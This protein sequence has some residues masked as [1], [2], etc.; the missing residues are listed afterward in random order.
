MITPRVSRRH[1]PLF[2]FTLFAVAAVLIGL[3]GFAAIT[4]PRL[5]DNGA[6]EPGLPAEESA[7]PVE[8]AMPPSEPPLSPPEAAPPG[9][10]MPPLRT[11][12]QWQLTQPVDQSLDVAMY[13]VDLFETDARVI[14]SLRA[15]GRK[16]ICYVSVGAWENWRPDANRF[17]EAVKGKQNGWPGERWLDI[18]RLDILA[19]LM[20]AR[21]DLCK[22]KGFDGVEPDNVD[23]H[24][25]DTGFPLTFQDQLR[26]NVFIANA[27][28]RRGLSVGLKND[29]PQ[30]RELLP[31]FD[32]AMNEE[33]FERNRCELLAPFI[34]AGKAV[35]HVEYAL[36]PADFCSRAN[37]MNFNSLRKRLDL[38]AHREACR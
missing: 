7:P 20:E 15:R 2:P 11:S 38:D 24:I 25:A 22:A 18:R 3:T 36:S 30:V 28:H 33:C 16:V 10:W 5:Q 4:R 35:F 32:W 1:S 29:L 17:P 8:P 34:E 12:W 21:L 26:F 23:G 9:V 37:A 19:P 6:S 14:T 31:Y 13:D 27:A